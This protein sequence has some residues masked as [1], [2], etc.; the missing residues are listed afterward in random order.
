MITI[1]IFLAGIFKLINFMFYCG[2]FKLIISFLFFFFS[3]KIVYVITNL[4][5]NQSQLTFKRTYRYHGLFYYNQSI[6]TG[7]TNINSLPGE[8]TLN[9]TKKKYSP[10]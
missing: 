2:I 1:Y 7:K 8:K 4:K 6:T 9:I 5:N 3:K 10:Y